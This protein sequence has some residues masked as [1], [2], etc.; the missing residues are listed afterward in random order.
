MGEYLKSFWSY[1]SKE[2]KSVVSESEASEVSV[3]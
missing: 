3:K 2:V 1:E